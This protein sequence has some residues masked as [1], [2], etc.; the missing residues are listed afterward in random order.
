[1]GRRYHAVCNGLCQVLSQ[2]LTNAGI[3]LG[4][5]CNRADLGIASKS[6]VI[7]GDI[8]LAREI[9]KKLAQHNIKIT[10]AQK[11]VDL[12]TDR[13]NSTIAGLNAATRIAAAWKQVSKA[14]K[15]MAA[16]RTGKTAARR[17]IRRG[18]LPKVQYDAAIY[19]MSPSSVQACRR[20]IGSTFASSFRGRC[21]DT[22]LQLELG[23]QDP[24]ISQVF[25]MLDSWM[26]ILA[27]SSQARKMALWDWSVHVER[28]RSN[29]QHR[30]RNITGPAGATVNT[31]LDINWDPIGPWHWVSDSGNG[32]HATPEILEAGPLDLDPPTPAC[33][34]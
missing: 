32:Y 15:R 19:G 5:L 1:M 3:L 7:S 28:A 25:K 12:G 24:A 13:G 17:V 21:L 6:K 18:G 22:I 8:G 9:A 14:R 27:S 4:W 20:E 34:G 2:A 30:W 10:V 31:L 23:D 33:R 29:P 26:S 11:A 16:G